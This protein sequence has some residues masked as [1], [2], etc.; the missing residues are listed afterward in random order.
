[1]NDHHLFLNYFQIM[2]PVA[3][4]LDYLQGETDMFIGCLLPVINDLREK[5]QKFADLSKEDIQRT[6]PSCYPLVLAL[7]KGISQRFASIDTTDELKIATSIHPR[8]RLKKLRADEA[9]TRMLLVLSKLQ[10]R[11]G[12]FGA[13]DNEGS[14]EESFFSDDN[15]H[16]DDSGPIVP[17]NSRVPNEVLR[18]Y[19]LSKTGCKQ[20]QPSAFPNDEIKMMFIRYNT[21]L[22]TSASVERMFSAGGRIFQ[23]LRCSISDTNFE[24]QLLFKMNRK[25]MK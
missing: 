12:D 8:F 2:S 23:P 3:R 22:P 24:R 16:D 20:V 10:Q 7:L 17:R 11:Q 19:L 13:T 25:H 4:A 18:E 21:A 6:L 1:M 14:V 9:E 5:L 15:D